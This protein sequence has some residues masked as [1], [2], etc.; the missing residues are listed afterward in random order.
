MFQAPRRRQGRSEA[1]S[2]MY[3]T[4]PLNRN[5][6]IYIRKYPAAD[7]TSAARKAKKKNTKIL[8]ILSDTRDRHQT[9]APQHG[10][11]VLM[12]RRREYSRR[13]TT[14]SRTFA[15][16][17]SYAPSPTQL[18]STSSVV[19]AALARN[20][21]ARTHTRRTSKTRNDKLLKEGRLL[22]NNNV[23]LLLIIVQH[24]IISASHNRCFTT[25]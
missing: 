1:R 10:R 8:S 21:V 6:H 24:A 15:Y 17:I 11:A 23:I 5:T 12:H 9:L 25:R 18:C 2:V 19:P 14:G 7:P 13:S 3:A 20:A 16:L 22:Q 4:Y